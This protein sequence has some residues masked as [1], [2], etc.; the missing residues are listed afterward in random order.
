MMVNFLPKKITFKDSTLKINI[1]CQDVSLGFT[2]LTTDQLNTV[3]DES[4]TNYTF[5]LSVDFLYK[6]AFTSNT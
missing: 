1:P 4:T 6:I 3:F 2:S 5:K